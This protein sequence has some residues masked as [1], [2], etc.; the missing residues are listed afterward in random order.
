MMLQGPCTDVSIG[1]RGSRSGSLF[2]NVSKMSTELGFQI[3]LYPGAQTYPL[4]LMSQSQ[5]D[6][7][8]RI[9]R[10]IKSL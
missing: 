2:S 9:R 1:T 8:L 7:I 10:F 6:F 3:W 5:D 4:E